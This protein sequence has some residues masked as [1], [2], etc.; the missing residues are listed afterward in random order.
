MDV[1]L[2]KQLALPEFEITDLKSNDTS[3]GVYVRK[4]NPPSFCPL[5]GVYSPRLNVHKHRE[6]PVR[7]L[8]SFGKHVNL[9]I[10]RVYY[11]C[12][13]CNGYFPE[14]LDSVAEQGRITKRL[15]EYLGQRAI[16]TPFSTLQKEYQVSD[17]TIRE[18]FLERVKSIPTVSQM[19]TPHVLGIDEICLMDNKYRQKEPWA[20]IANGDENTVMEMLQDRSKPSII[21]LLKSLSC[22]ETVEVV[23]MDMWSGYRSAAYEVLQNAVVV[24]D[25]FHVVKMANEEMDSCRKYYY[26]NAPPELKKS[27]N[28][29]LKRATDLKPSS[30]DRRDEWFNLYPKLKVAY[31]LKEEFFDIYAATSRT[32][33]QQRFLD[34]QRNIPPGTDYNGYRKLASTVRRRERE[35]FNYF[36]YPSTNAFVEGLNATIRAIATSGRGYDFPVLRG[37][38]LLTIGRK[39]EFPPADFG[40]MSF[41]MPGS[42]SLG[43]VSRKKDYGIPFETII[44][45]A[46]AGNYRL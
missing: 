28:L 35:I 10:D 22:P 16:S 9:Y 40:N 43:N 37:K 4:K 27:K 8:E 3:M 33:A 15:R 44:Q 1:L 32:E 45:N 39:V 11:H 26:K 19:V 34:W 5:C 13:E 23:T 46:K 12:R 30:R 7:D 29:F 24:V 31:D 38:V 2:E 36:D 41:M 17:T 25:K 42:F 21:R 18:A 6:Q 14:P 20:V